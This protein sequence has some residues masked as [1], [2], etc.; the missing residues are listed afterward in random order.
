MD[1]IEVGGCKIDIMTL[2]SEEVNHCD[3]AKDAYAR[4]GRPHVD[5]VSEEIIFDGFD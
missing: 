3:Q 1:V 5:G 2:P 4:G